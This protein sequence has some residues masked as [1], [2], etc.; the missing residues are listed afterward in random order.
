MVAV[1]QCLAGRKFVSGGT[2]RVIACIGNGSWS[3]RIEDCTG[4]YW[5]LM[6]YPNQSAACYQVMS[7]NETC[8][9][10]VYYCRLQ[11][12]TTDRETSKILKLHDI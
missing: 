11:L 12:E 2:V 3:V 1:Y 5:H 4:G 6:M 8:T 10:T 7:W 9:D